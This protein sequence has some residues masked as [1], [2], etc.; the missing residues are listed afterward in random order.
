MN[1]VLA[2]AEK[3]I[4]TVMEDRMLNSYIEHTILKPDSS[5][6]QVLKVCR[7]AVENNFAGA[8]IP[9]YFLQ[10]ARKEIPD[11][12]ETQLVT[13]IGFPMG[14]NMTSIKAE[15]AKK[16]IDDGADEL[17]M[18]MNIAAFKSGNL[19]FVQDDIESIVTI[20]RLK[21]KLVK[22]I[23]ET[24]LL[25]DEEIIKACA[26]CAKAEVPYVKTSTGINAGGAKSE[27]VKLMREHLPKSIKIKAS[28]GIRSTEFA[29]E[30]IELG[31]DRLGTSSGLS[32]INAS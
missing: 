8:C 7:E 21:N 22:V 4:K 12:S 6:E 32:L 13:V 31:A 17:D 3:S 19:P 29:N 26:I 24:G 9:P 28:G 1:P 2:E 30:L 11:N 23:I 15:E 5:R 27:H 10:H 20:G 25:S 14:Y 16:A 18:V